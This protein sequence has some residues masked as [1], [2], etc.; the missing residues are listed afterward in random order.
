VSEFGAEPRIKREDR[1]VVVEA[2]HEN[3]SNRIDELRQK[4]SL[5]E[6]SKNL[7]VRHKLGHGRLFQ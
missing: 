7:E 4:L 6:V 2:S 1:Q 5:F 3:T